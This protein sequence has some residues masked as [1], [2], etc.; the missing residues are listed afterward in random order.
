MIVFGVCAGK[1][2]RLET[3]CQPSLATFAPAAQTIVLRDQPSIASAYNEILR[4]CAM[5]AEIEAIVLLHD[6]VALDNDAWQ[7][8]ILD[9][10]A[11]QTVAVIGVVGG[12]GPGGMAWFTRAAKFGFVTEPTRVHAYDRTAREVDVVDGVVLVLSRWAI[13]NLRF[14]ESLYPPFHG[15][16]ADICAQARAHGMKVIV[17][18]IDV[19][20]HTNGAF[21]TT[22][23]YEDWIRASLRWKLRW[24][25]L[26]APQRAI[27]RARTALVPLE[28]RIR[29]ST[30]NRRRDLIRRARPS[31][32]PIVVDQ[33]D[34]SGLAETVVTVVI[35]AF[36]AAATLTDQLAALDRQDC[37]DPFHVIVVDN[38]SSDTTAVIARTY[39]AR[40]YSVQVVSEAR[41]GVNV[42]RNAGIAAAADGTILVCDADDCVDASWIS[43]MTSRL[44]PGLWVSGELD[45]RALNNPQ[46][47][48]MWGVP[49]RTFHVDSQPFVDTGFGGN[50]GF[51]RAMWT[52]LGGFDDSL[53]G[54]GDENEFF[55]RAWSHGYALA[56]SPDSVVQC[57]LRPGQRA[58]VRQRYRKG[59]SVVRMRTRAGGALVPRDRPSLVAKSIVW[60]AV[61]TP[62]VPFN[63]H[64]RQRWLYA[65]AYRA[66]HL[67]GVCAQVVDR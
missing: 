11:D 27:T 5:R 60:L 45:Y 2:G 1:S 40:R 23:S 22:R 56:W 53:S 10:L 61:V 44:A 3:I 59:L 18:P 35:P 12:S 66:G 67:V 48:A 57:R 33:T 15:Y 42:A 50:C 36:N 51:T 38:A 7:A 65:G 9:V 31:W 41:R 39:P 58:M 46:T 28:V 49:N 26:T 47:I 63:Q 4:R 32:K 13:Q 29:P 14:E 30:R 34:T 8:T 16:D 24:T 62:A 37:A 54:A 19:T 20:H 55:F 17:A 64:L 21:G 43:T 6:D 52:E 25:P